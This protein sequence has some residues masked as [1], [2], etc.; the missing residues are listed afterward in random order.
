MTVTA[1]AAAA[2]ALCA[3]GLG[4]GRTQVAPPGR[5]QG[6]KWPAGGVMEAAVRLDAVRYEALLPTRGG[7]FC[8]LG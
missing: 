8:G 2:A 7:P 4:D 5:S 6:S 1:S 3:E